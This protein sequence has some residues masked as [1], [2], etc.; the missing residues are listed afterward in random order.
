MTEVQLHG[1][2]ITA[3]AGTPRIAYAWVTPYY[4]YERVGPDMKYAARLHVRKDPAYNWW[5]SQFAFT[6]EIGGI[7]KSATYDTPG[8]SVNE[9]DV[10]LGPWEIRT[11]DTTGV[12]ASFN[13]STINISTSQQFPPLPFAAIVT[14]PVAPDIR[15]MT[16]PG[17]INIDEIQTDGVVPGAVKVMN[18]SSVWVEV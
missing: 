5:S 4:S 10:E 11:R 9:F 18:E 15:V 14:D 3:R 8:I 16:E 12:P 6:A 2:I 7:E 13:W 1:E 17:F